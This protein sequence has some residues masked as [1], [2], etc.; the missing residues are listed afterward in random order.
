M[1]T[2]RTSGATNSDRAPAS[3][4]A[5]AA[6]MAAASALSSAACCRIYCEKHKSFSGV[7]VR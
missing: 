6:T 5:E 3:F 4:A 7:G 1:R 2:T